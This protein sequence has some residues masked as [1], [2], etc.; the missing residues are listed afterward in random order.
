VLFRSD[1]LYPEDREHVIQCCAHIRQHPEIKIN[2][3]LVLGGAQG[4]GKDTIFAGLER[5]VGMS[6]YRTV[7][8]HQII[9]PDFN[10]ELKTVV[11]YISEVHDLGIGDRIKFYNM[12]KDKLATPPTTLR[13]NEKN[14]QP[15][16]IP[17]L[18]FAV[19]TTNF[20]TGGIYLPKDDRRHY[21]CWSQVEKG[22]H[23][24]EWW[25]DYYRW[26]NG[27]GDQ[28]IAG[29][30]AA[31]DLSSFNPKAE[32]P[33]TEAWHAMVNASLSSEEVELTNVL[34]QFEGG[35]ATIWMI[36]NKAHELGYE[37][38]AK[39]LKDPRNSKA[40]TAR[41]ED[42]GYSCIRNPDH[43]K[44]RWRVKQLSGQAKGKTLQHMV[45]G[46]VMEDR[47]SVV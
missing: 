2:H 33:K 26:F 43:R 32:P 1:E 14:R 25:D 29:Y 12:M 6:N 3:A 11:L 47:K 45:Y 13:I 30:L 46:P 35:A 15:Y 38:L 10:G 22:N 18:L 36:I 8:P 37:A 7:T 41:I 17:N 27:G 44:G 19:M 23:S 40:A 9:N 39:W 28:C 24:K 20:K 42:A 34:E 16:F 31:Y 21:I 5:A 4:I